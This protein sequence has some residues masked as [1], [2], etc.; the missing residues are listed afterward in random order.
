V[1]LDYRHGINPLD[2]LM[3]NASGHAWH[4]DDVAGPGATNDPSVIGGFLDAGAE[5]II[6]PMAE[7]VHDATRAVAACRY[8]RPGARSYG[9][10]RTSTSRTAG[11]ANCC[12][13]P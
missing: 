4:S 5:G 11:D 13:W 9:G 1:W 7:D 2:N 8:M 12:V 6:V 3:P 10:L